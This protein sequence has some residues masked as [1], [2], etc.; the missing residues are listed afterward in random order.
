MHSL[1]ENPQIVF[2]A[3][4]VYSIVIETFWQ[5]N[6]LSY[7]LLNPLEAKRQQINY[8]LAFSQN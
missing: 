3:T 7:C 4:G 5:N 2:E 6:H 1:P 8:R